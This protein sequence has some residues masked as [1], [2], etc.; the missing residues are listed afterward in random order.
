MYA[1]SYMIIVKKYC[2]HSIT[3]QGIVII[4]CQKRL[5]DSHRHSWDPFHIM[6][7][8]EPNSFS[9]QGIQFFCFDI[10]TLV[11][12]Y[13]QVSLSDPKTISFCPLCFAVAFW[14]GLSWWKRA[15]LV[16]ATDAAAPRQSWQIRSRIQSPCLIPLPCT[17]GTSPHLREGRPTV[18]CEHLS[19]PVII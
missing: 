6:T 9:A 7:G 4:H 12:Q 18:F 19:N 8:L 17:F 14:W 5:K 3:N 13:L 15:W 10:P 16:P 11:M 1:L 2:Y